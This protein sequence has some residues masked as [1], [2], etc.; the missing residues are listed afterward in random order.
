LLSSSSLKPYVESPLTLKVTARTVA[1]ATTATLTCVQESEGARI[2]VCFQIV[3]CT[4]GYEATA[5]TATDVG[6]NDD[7]ATPVDVYASCRL[8]NQRDP[9]R[10][11]APEMAG[12]RVNAY[13][14]HS[15]W[16]DA[17]KQN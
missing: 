14:R 15:S 11:C 1:I 12:V 5:G 6:A 8:F 3:G 4:G 9:E 2:P 7:P 17:R 13:T 10:G 16:L